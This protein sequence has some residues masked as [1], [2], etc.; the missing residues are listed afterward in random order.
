MLSLPP[1][2]DTV[3]ERGSLGR[4]ARGRV[5]TRAR[6]VLRGRMLEREAARSE[7]AMLPPWR[8]GI[9]WARVAERAGLDVVRGQNAVLRV[10]PAACP[11]GQTERGDGV[12]ARSGSVPGRGTRSAKFRQDPMMSLPPGACP[13]GRTDQADGVDAGSGSV[14]GPRSANFGEDPMK[15]ETEQADG[16][17][18]GS[19]S[20]PGLRRG[21]ALGQGV[22]SAKC[23]QDSILCLP[24]GARPD[25]S[26]GGGCIPRVGAA[27][28]IVRCDD[29]AGDGR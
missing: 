10:P 6:P 8:A 24:P 22:W 18:A 9:A 20:V 17:D 5:V 25:G 19:G 11:G 1:G 27:E 15:R 16:V 26:G 13:G 7:A 28:D 29:L 4:D 2:N 12:D 14:P 21:G 3:V 23:G